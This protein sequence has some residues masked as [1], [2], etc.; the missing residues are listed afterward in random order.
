MKSNLK[1]YREESGLT[2][3]ELADLAGTCKSQ[4]H[5]MEQDGTNPTLESAFAVSDALD[6]KITE[7]WGYERL[8]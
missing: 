2:M 8:Y 3:Q 1:E 5:A 7:L 6:V 4:I